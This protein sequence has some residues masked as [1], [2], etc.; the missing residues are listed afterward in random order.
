M[1]SVS[2]R[3]VLAL[4]VITVLN[5]YPAA[6]AQRDDGQFGPRSIFQRVKQLIIQVLEDGDLSWPKP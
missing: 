5:T 6:A 1:R 2:K 4:V 3:L